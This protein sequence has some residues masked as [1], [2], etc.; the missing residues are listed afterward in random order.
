[1]TTAPQHS[2][3]VEFIKSTLI[4]GLLV[5]LP[6]GLVVVLVM[7]IVGLL[8]G[9][10]APIANHLPEQLRFPTVIAAA[11]LLA[12]CLAAG[13]VARTRAGRSAGSFFER[14]FL[15]HVPG[16]AL[17]RTLVRSVASIEE[18]DTFRPALVEIEESLVP[19]FVVEAHPD[20]RYTVFV[21]SAPTPGIGV[22]YIMAA[23]RVHLLD[24]SLLKTIKCI[25]RWGAGSGELVLAMRESQT[26]V[27][28][29]PNRPI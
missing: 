3:L 2:P 24:I 7:K 27:G 14:V 15:K 16:Y 26:A 1:M 21:P 4:G 9:V 20:G 12:A 23:E 11:L 10:I 5:I 19:A 17:V 13:L 22:I 25:S 8:E 18:S 28:E 29:A 6:I